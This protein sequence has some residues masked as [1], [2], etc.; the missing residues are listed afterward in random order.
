MAHV[1]NTRE[2]VDKL[3]R[4][5]HKVQLMPGPQGHRY[6]VDGEESYTDDELVMLASGVKKEDIQS[7]RK[8]TK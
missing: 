8:T 5:G 6:A 7:Q 1:L 4:Q 2:A 3:T